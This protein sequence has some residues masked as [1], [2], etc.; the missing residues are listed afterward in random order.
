MKNLLMSIPDSLI[1]KRVF[2]EIQEINEK[3]LEF[4]LRLSE[5]DIKVVI[6]N[7]TE[8]LKRTGRVEFGA[9]VLTK[10]ISSF[11]D[12]PYILQDNYVELINDLVETFYYYKSETMEEIGDDELIDFMKEYF[13]NKCQGD[14]EL[15]K[16]RYL[17]QVAHNV[18]Y[19]E[20]DYFDV[21]KGQEDEEED[22]EQQYYE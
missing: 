22:D 12:S 20:R 7:R 4:G 18:K 11:C 17:E 8:A 15:L 6:S 5:R 14:L 1:V 9:G 21:D 3:T 16:H 13:D 2:T 10:I 19:G